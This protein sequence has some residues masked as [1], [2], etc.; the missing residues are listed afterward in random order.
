MHLIDHFF[1]LGELSLKVIY[2]I[3]VEIFRLLGHAANQTVLQ[4]GVVEE[5][6]KRFIEQNLLAFVLVLG[7]LDEY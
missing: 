1:S 6:L 5:A 2:G 4:G 7:H 3:I